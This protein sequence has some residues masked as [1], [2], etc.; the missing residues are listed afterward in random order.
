MGVPEVPVSPLFLKLVL[1]CAEPATTCDGAADSDS[2]GLD[3]CAE[4]ELGTDAQVADSDGD[5][6]SD[7]EE[8]GCV[9][10]PLD[11]AELCYSCGWPHGDPGT[12]SSTGTDEGDVVQ[13]LALLDQCEEQLPL[14]DLAGSWR[15]VF[16]TAEWCGA[17]LTEAMELPD[18]HADFT[19]D[20][21][22]IPFSPVILLFE[23][24]N[25]QLPDAQTAVRYTETVS[26]TGF[27]VV[28]DP[29]AAIIDA[30]PYRGDSLPGLCVLS[31]DMVM[32]ECTQGHGKLDDLVELIV[33]Q[34]GG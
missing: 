31:P 16:M 21:P 25:G 18:L 17:C 2:D 3:D 4:I 14:W 27:P 10:D 34:A 22:G 24:K 15:L 13:N 28:A 19:A 1:A 5:G 30:T 11:A 32:L 12:L 33:E 29:A 9:S 8:V 7:G 6:L 23:D 20:H 26:A